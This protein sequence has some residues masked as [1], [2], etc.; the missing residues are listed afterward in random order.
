MGQWLP[1]LHSQPYLRELIEESNV[2][3]PSVYVYKQCN[4]RDH[5][6]PEPLTKFGRR[7]MQLR[8]QTYESK[9]CLTHRELSVNLVLTSET[10]EL[11]GED[12][13]GR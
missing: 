13:K 9:A 3:K 10:G 2:D 11:R 12:G 5:V 6:F 4:W 8:G 1:R 7:K